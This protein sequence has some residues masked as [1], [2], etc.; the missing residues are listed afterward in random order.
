MDD[1]KYTP[2]GVVLGRHHIWGFRGTG[3]EP[4]ITS[5]DI[6]VF[7]VDPG[8]AVANDGNEGL[9]PEEP[10]ATLA[11]CLANTVNPVTDF[12]V[13][14][15]NGDLSESVITGDSVVGPNY[16]TLIGGGPNRYSPTWA[17]GA[18]D[19]PCLD[20]RAIGWRVTG[21]RFTGAVS[22]SCVVLR[23]T[24]TNANDISA[25]SIIDNN[26]FDGLTTGLR[27]IASHG[28][29]D[30]WIVNNTFTSFHTA[31]ITGIGMETLAT[32]LAIPYGNHVIGNKFYDC[33]NG[34]L[35]SS[36]GS[37][38]SENVVQPTGYTYAMTIAFQTS[39][40]AKLGDDN[41]VYGNVF[42]G[43]FSLAGGYGGGAADAWLGNFADDVAE[44]EVG[45][46]GFTILAP[47]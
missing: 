47:T 41:I 4:A 1:F 27:G 39:T 16:I 28:S 10:F 7:Y 45:D 36:N 24:D 29:Y 46:N 32:P 12:D 37:L 31:G 38:F 5:G 42:P 43:D 15:V 8:H 25:R 18:V 13:I 3:S 35:W 26:H 30:V 20:L 19:A 22:E 34:M 2:L 40:A 21:F 11:G 17:S 33:D 9:E 6:K 23:Y 14:R 44:A